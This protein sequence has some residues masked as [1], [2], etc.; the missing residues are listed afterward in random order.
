LNC[1]QKF[2]IQS[3]SK[4]FHKL[5]YN[6]SLICIEKAYYLN[7][8]RFGNT[9]PYT[10]YFRVKLDHEKK[11]NKSNG[12]SYKPQSA[13]PK[14]KVIISRDVNNFE[15]IGKTSTYHFNIPFSN[16]YEP[17]LITINDVDKGNYVKNLYFDKQGLFKYFRMTPSNEMLYQENILTR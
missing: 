7:L 12:N 15:F 9:H 5:S 2:T 14:E 8:G 13:I 6:N 3:V 17:L 11:L 16:I 1:L 4:N 10:E